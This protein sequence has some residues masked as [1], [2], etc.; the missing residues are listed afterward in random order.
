M[1]DGSSETTNSYQIAKVL[2]DHFSTIVEKL[3][4]NNRYNPGPTQTLPSLTDSA[5][6]HHLSDLAHV[7]PHSITKLLYDIPLTKAAGHD[8]LNP[9][10]LR[11]CLP[12]I[13][14]PVCDIMNRAITENTFPTE[15]K[16]ALVTPLH[17]SGPTN[18]PNNYR[19]I[20]V[21]PI[22]SKVFERHIHNTL[23]KHLL[24]NKLIHPN[25]SGF[26][27]NHSCTTSLYKLHTDWL[28]TKKGEKT[29]IV[30]IDFKKAFDAVP[31]D[32]LIK[33]LSHAGIT[34]SFL[35]LLKSF[36]AERQQQV[37]VGNSTSPLRTM[38][39]GVPQGSILSPTL[40]SIF[41]NDLLS[42]TTFLQSHAYADDTV[43]YGSDSSTGILCRK[44]QNDINVINQWCI[45]NGMFIN[46]NKFHFI[47][48]N[49]SETVDL[50]ICNSSLAQTSS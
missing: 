35:T 18:D 5:L 19:P 6:Q 39:F 45:D 50:L 29:M 2:N 47:I 37:K 7:T 32:I 44:A 33:K 14:S 49:T 48:T 11:I 34:G 4:A 41:I 36:L 12:Y 1:F 38:N 17:K 10:F 13:L 31:H 23:N 15:W 22:F 21:L 40:F 46:A 27:A 16:H 43:F 20:S 24:S 8:H 42:S 25:Q 3:D 9:C 28:N 26:R 30:F